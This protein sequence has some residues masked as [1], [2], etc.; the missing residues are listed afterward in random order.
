[1]PAAQAYNVTMYILAAMLLAGLVCNLLVRPVADRHFMTDAE[2][3]DERKRAHETVAVEAVTGS[4]GSTA[5]T[6]AISV[7][8]AWLAVGIPLCWGIWMTLTKA[9][10]LFPPR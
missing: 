9:L 7:L 2:L 3:A 8:F 6:P 4:R 10:P 1:M 5:A